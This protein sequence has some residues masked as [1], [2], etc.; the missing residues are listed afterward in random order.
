MQESGNDG[1]LKT[2]REIL[3]QCEAQGLVDLELGGHTY[4]R[5]ASVVQGMVGDR[6]LAFKFKYLQV[7][8]CVAVVV[9][10]LLSQ[11]FGVFE[12]NHPCTEA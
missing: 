2:L 4:S 8:F 9:V 11:N 1:P 7:V 3:Q 6:L 12:S 10:N 5:P